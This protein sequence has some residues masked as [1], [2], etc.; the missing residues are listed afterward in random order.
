MV[1]PP[2]AAAAPIRPATGTCSP[3]ATEVADDTQIQEAFATATDDSVICVIADI[4]VSATL[5]LDD[6]SLRLEGGV[7]PIGLSGNSARQ[8]MNVDYTGSDDDTLTIVGVQFSDGNSS[9][10]GGALRIEGENG[11]QDALVVSRSTF[12]Q[13][14]AAD[15]GGAVSV[16]NVPNV[17]IGELAQFLENRSL[18]GSGGALSATGGSGTVRIGTS[19]WQDNRTLGAGSDGGAIAADGEIAVNG[20]GFFSNRATDDG[21]ALRSLVNVTVTDTMFSENLA[22]DEGGALWGAGVS[23]TTSTFTDDTAGDLGGAIYSSGAVTS[24]RGVFRGNLSDS[25]GA[26]YAQGNVTSTDDSFTMNGAAEDF[27]HLIWWDGGAIR[28]GANV[29]VTGGTFTQNGAAH[30]GGAIWAAQSLSVLNSTFDTNGSDA[31]GGALWGAN[32]TVD[33]STLVENGYQ[34]LQAGG[35]IFADDTVTLTNVTSQRNEA[36]AG[37]FLALGSSARSA[38]LRYVTSLD[39]TGV[40][41]SALHRAGSGDVALHGVLLASQYAGDLCDDSV[42]P[43]NFTV[44]SSGSLTTDASCGLADDSINLVTI[45]EIGSLTWRTPSTPGR[46][47]LEPYE[48][49]VLVNAVPSTLVPGVTTDQLGESRAVPAGLTT[50]GAVQVLPVPYYTTDP[51]SQTV[52]AGSSVT[53]TS[54][55]AGGTGALDYAW[56]RSVDGGVNWTSIPGALTSTYTIASPSLSDSGMQVRGLVSDVNGQQGLSTAA[57]LTVTAPP[58]PG[59]GPGPAPSPTPTPSPTPSP[60]APG[61]PTILGVVPGDDAALVEF[62]P[63]DDTTTRYEYSLDDSTWITPDPLVTTSPMVISGLEPGTS[64]ALRLRAVNAVGAGEPSMPV[65]FATRSRV[66]LLITGTRERDRITVF[67]RTTGL[68]GASVTPRIK[69][70]GQ[71]VYVSGRVAPLVDSAGRFEWSRKTGKKAYVYFAAEGVRSNSVTIPARKGS[72]R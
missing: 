38:D 63:V 68:V 70:R 45:D 10:D 62:A 28:S 25:G 56:Q 35:A 21:G 48:S 52:M 24:A 37:G 42:G 30:R 23:A 31:E 60:A 1:A 29:T 67:G 16:V 18:G 66:T 27:S 2:L 59:P 26:I 57:I 58:A 15:S 40:D 41:G 69:L 11:G 61:T 3:G 65:Q 39:D 47:I 64:Y 43:A 32:V 50:V 22:L 49:S 13:S 8:I 34:F 4:T 36:V 19:F 54:V 33:A 46:Q 6:T 7:S 12:F 53:F 5:Q 71:R 51:T 20:A 9:A 72:R 17:S 55:A 14:T 44:G